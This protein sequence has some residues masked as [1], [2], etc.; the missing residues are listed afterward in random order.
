[1]DWERWADRS[2]P[3]SRIAWA[4]PSEAGEPS[5]ADTPADVTSTAIARS[6]S[7]CRAIASA[8]GLRQV[9]PWQTKTMRIGE[10]RVR[11]Y[12][13]ITRSP[14]AYQSSSLPVYRSS[15]AERRIFIVG[16]S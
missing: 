4:A 12:S 8:M 1:M 10:D 5:W 3:R 9:L 6:L 15:M 2:R 11:S 13:Q 16:V 7:H 14:D